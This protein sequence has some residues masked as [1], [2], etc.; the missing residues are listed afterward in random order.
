MSQKFY[1]GS[2]R[3]WSTLDTV[4]LQFG[5]ATATFTG[6]RSI[7]T[8]AEYSYHCQSVNSFQDPLLVMVNS[9]GNASEWRLN[10]VDFQVQLCILNV[11]IC[12]CLSLLNCYNRY[13][14]FPFGFVL[15]YRFRA[16]AW[17]IQEISPTPA[18]AQ[19]SSPLGFGWGC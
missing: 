3:N 7:H 6:N 14:F 2:A 4:Q 8:P 15:H 19:A 12:L 17:T 10:F 18:T 1:P 9:T 5:S 13:C 11:P 16:L